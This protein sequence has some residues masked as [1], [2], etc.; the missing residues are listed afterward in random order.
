MKSFYVFTA[1]FVFSL[2]YSCCERQ[3]LSFIFGKDIVLY[4]WQEAA[5]S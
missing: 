5:R 1:I 4:L 2:L 3:G